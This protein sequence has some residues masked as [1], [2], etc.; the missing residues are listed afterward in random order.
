MV[1]W[2]EPKLLLFFTVYDIFLSPKI[3]SSCNSKQSLKLY[4]VI[5]ANGIPQKLVTRVGRDS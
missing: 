4:D 1:L 5:A 2:R 3:I